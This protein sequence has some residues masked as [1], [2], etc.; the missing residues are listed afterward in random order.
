M[1]ITCYRFFLLPHMILIR[2]VKFGH[3]SNVNNDT[4][5]NIYV[6]NF[7]RC[8]SGHYRVAGL[9]ALSFSFSSTSLIASAT[10]TAALLI[11]SSTT[12]FL[13]SL[14]EGKASSP[15]LKRPKNPNTVAIRFILNIGKSPGLKSADNWVRRS[16]FRFYSQNC[17]AMHVITLRKKK[18]CIL[19]RKIGVVAILELFYGRINLSGLFHNLQQ[20]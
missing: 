5:W 14:G 16:L 20:K 12:L 1:Y 11:L 19:A 18:R 15:R 4:H 3:T 6:K 10:V 17:F 9:F 13:F 2:L 7:F 8:W